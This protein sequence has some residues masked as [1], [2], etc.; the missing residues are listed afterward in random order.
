MSNPVGKKSNI[1]KAMAMWY[2]I[3]I[4]KLQDALEMPLDT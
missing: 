3:L 4:H 1:K 2:R